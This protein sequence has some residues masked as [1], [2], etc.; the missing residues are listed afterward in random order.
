M[1]QF[2]LN[3]LY[4]FLGLFLTLFR[5]F[6]S[7]IKVSP[8]EFKISCVCSRSSTIPAEN[9]HQS[10]YTISFRKGL[11]G[12]DLHVVGVNALIPCRPYSPSFDLG[13]GSLQKFDQTLK[14]T[15]GLSCKGRLSIITSGGTISTIP[16]RPVYD[17][18]RDSGL[19]ATVSRDENHFSVASDFKSTFLNYFSGLGWC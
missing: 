5:K 18:D 15:S 8:Y 4:P 2:I 13:P 11:V 16:V 6:I 19:L 14:R 9:V 1:V 17:L 10:N 12:W 3:V 7:L